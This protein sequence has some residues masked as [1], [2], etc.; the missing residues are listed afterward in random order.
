MGS[1]PAGGCLP[2][3]GCLVVSVW[4]VNVLGEGAGRPR[5]RCSGTWCFLG[6]RWAT[7]PQGPCTSPPRPSLGRASA[8]GPEWVTG[9]SP[10]AEGD[11]ERR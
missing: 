2:P 1:L 5:C 8:S 10:E 9:G 11:V 4:W 3:E 7:S 6:L